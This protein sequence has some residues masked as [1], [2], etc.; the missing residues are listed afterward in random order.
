LT[1]LGLPL[2]LGGSSN[3][4]RT[5]VLREVGGWD[6]YNVTEDADL[7]FRLRRFGYRSVTF[8]STTFEE[9]PIT[10]GNWLR[11]RTRWMKGWVQTWQV[12]M[13]KP[14]R[15]WRQLGPGGFVTLNVMVGG[16]VLTALVF[17][18][19]LYTLLALMLGTAFPKAAWLV[20]ELPTPL[21]MAAIVAGCASTVVVGLMGL[22]QRRQLGNGWVLA[23]T[24]LHWLCLSLAAWRAVAQYVWSPYQWEKTT[25]GIAERPHTVAPAAISARPQLRHARHR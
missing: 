22:A 10:F 19:L 21:H 18:I 4:F 13:R 8:C 5:A 17:P 3:H 14:V 7:G 9:A 15:L 2:P 11:Q 20:P 16:T 23:L 12:H 1:A 24:P 6:P 25:H